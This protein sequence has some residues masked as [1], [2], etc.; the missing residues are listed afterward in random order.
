[1][2]FTEDFSPFFDND[3]GF[4]VPAVVGTTNVDVIFD[5][6]Y[7][8]VSIGGVPVAGEY[9]VIVCQEALVTVTY[10]TYVRVNST[11]YKV[12]DWQPDGTGLTTIVLE[13]Q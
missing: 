10:G 6:E 5:H 8:E 13:E 1:M 7:R 12:V 3:N 9:P 2:A 4:S 11:T